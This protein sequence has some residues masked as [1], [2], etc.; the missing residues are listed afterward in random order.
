MK[1]TSVFLSPSQ[2]EKLTKRSEETGAPMAELIRRA[3]DDHFG[4]RGESSR[5][6]GVKP[7]SIGKE[8]RSR[9]Y[10]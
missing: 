9:I 1:R 10:A 5:R 6:E 2:H 3:I 4:K 7:P 8:K